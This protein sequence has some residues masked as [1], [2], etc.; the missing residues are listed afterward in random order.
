MFCVA[1]YPAKVIDFRH[2]DR[3]KEHYGNLVNYGYSDHSTDVLNVPLAAKAHGATI[4]EKH[5]NLCGY[6]DTDDAPH[7]INGAELAIMTRAL[8]GSLTIKETFRS[9]PYKRQLTPHGYYRPMP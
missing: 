1:E 2:L 8:K 3:L 4:I 9:N 7:S 5:V 6:T